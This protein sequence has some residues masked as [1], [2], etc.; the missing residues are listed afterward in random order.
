M[1][2]GLR[3]VLSFIKS[4]LIVVATTIVLALVIS[5]VMN[6]V[7]QITPQDNQQ[8][9]PQ[10][11]EVPLQMPEAMDDIFKMLSQH[12]TRE[13]LNIDRG[14]EVIFAN[15]EQKGLLG[16]SIGEHFEPSSREIWVNTRYWGSLNNDQRFALLAHESAHHFLL[17]N[18]TPNKK[19]YLYWADNKL[20]RATVEKQFLDD[21]QKVCGQK[22]R[23]ATEQE[24]TLKFLTPK[25][26]GPW[27]IAN[28][29]EVGRLSRD[30]KRS[31]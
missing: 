3:M 9:N 2:V 30:D 4:F 31:K 23:T 11:K 7:L 19:N 16:E 13:Q 8:D 26:R 17:L 22:I 18:H 10:I 24:A 15:F 6:F 28:F 25:V 21:I 27:R 14:Y 1:G 20:P 12:C 5:P 29:R